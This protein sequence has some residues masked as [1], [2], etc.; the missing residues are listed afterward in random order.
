[1]DGETKKVSVKLDALP[2][3]TARRWRARVGCTLYQGYGA[4]EACGAIA[5][6]PAGSPFPEGTV[7]RVAPKRE[8]RL[9][10]PQTLRPVDP[11]EPGE[12]WVSGPYLPSAYWNNP[13]ETEQETSCGW[14]ARGGC[15]SWIGPR[16]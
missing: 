13:E 16:T 8:V 9:V 10:D 3:K 1:M 12:L 11:E 4:T 14:T 5:L 7:G 6:I 15:S 2:A